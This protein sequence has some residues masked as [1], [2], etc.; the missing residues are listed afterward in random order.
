MPADL[1]EAT[2]LDWVGAVSPVGLI[3]IFVLFVFTGRVLPQRTVMFLSNERDQRLRELRDEADR[4][5]TVAELSQQELVSLRGQVD[6]LL[7]QAEVTVV[8]LQSI[9]NQAG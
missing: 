2:W 1:A 8:L 4:W 5:R 9:K 3:A 7:E 6:Q